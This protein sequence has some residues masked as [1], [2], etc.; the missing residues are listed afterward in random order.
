MHMKK[1]CVI[2]S[3]NIDITTTVDRFP[4]IGESVFSKTFDLFVGGGKGGNQSVALGKL[5]ADVMMVGKL[6]DQFYGPQYLEV[7]KDH[8]V[9]F[10]AIKIEKDTFSGA[11]LIAVDKNGDNMIFAY[12]GANS[13]VDIEFIDE[14]W[15]MISKCDIFLLQLEIPLE[16]NIFIIK[17]LKALDKIIIL[18]PAPAMKFPDELLNLIDYIT[19]NEHELE[20]LTGIVAQNEEDIKRSVN[21]LISRGSKTVIVKSGSKGSYIAQNNEFVHIP[22]FKIQAV[23]PTAAG[24]SFNAGLALKIAEGKDI[25]ESVKFANAVG[26]MATMSLGAQNAMPSMD[27][28]NQF[29]QVKNRPRLAK[30]RPRLAC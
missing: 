21:I 7:L 24:D 4:K 2:G 14:E 22:A 9:N 17:K 5:G 18:D 28:V 26:A 29:L 27:E 10:E 25:Y 30:N 8:N 6:G 3:L 13:K 12:P 1:I 20:S 23:D 16:T 15:D 19:P 11:A